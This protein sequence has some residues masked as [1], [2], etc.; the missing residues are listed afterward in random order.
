VND[1]TGFML[2]A[3]IACAAAAARFTPTGA[4]IRW[5]ELSR[6][7]ILPHAERTATESRPH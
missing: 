6:T 3:G 7:R 4:P 5:L 1:A 2:T